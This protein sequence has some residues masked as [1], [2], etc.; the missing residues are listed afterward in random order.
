M[1]PHACELTGEQR[2]QR[3]FASAESQGRPS[4][5]KRPAHP[6]SAVPQQPAKRGSRARRVPG[7]GDDNHLGRAYAAGDRDGV[8]SV[9]DRRPRVLIDDDLGSRARPRSGH[10]RRLGVVAPAARPAGE[11]DDVAGGRD[12]CGVLQPGCTDGVELTRS[13]LGI[14]EYGYHA[15]VA[16]AH[17]P[18]R[19]S[20]RKKS[21]VPTTVTTSLTAFFPCS[22]DSPLAR[23]RM[24]TATSST[25]SPS[26]SS[27]KSASTSGAPLT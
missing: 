2:P 3:Q 22:F 7:R 13:A 12:S 27:R 8:S 23:S 18:R 10:Q 6:H 14:P 11:D 26:D 24:W 19:R 15:R 16:L 25:R 4:R 17:E 9:F 20:Q 1:S 21:S 5:W